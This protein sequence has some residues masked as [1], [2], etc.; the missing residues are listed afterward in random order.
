MARHVVVVVVGFV[1]GPNSSFE[2]V[3][4]RHPLDGQ[5]F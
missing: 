4:S 1:R 3:P 2:I 5:L